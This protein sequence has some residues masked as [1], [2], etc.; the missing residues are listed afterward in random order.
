M[1][2]TFVNA[3][4][5]GSAASGNITLGAPASPQVD[6]VWI[7]VIHSSDQVAHSFTGWTQVV[8]GNGGGTTSR[9][10]GWYF[11]YAGSLPNLVVTHTAGQSPVGGIAAFRGCRNT[12]SP[13][14]LAGII[15]VG[16]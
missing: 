16:I 7:A 8:Q 14:N 4:T 1:A 11:R 3:G 6:D 12:G 13:I 9:F 10:S 2:I 5:K 15:A